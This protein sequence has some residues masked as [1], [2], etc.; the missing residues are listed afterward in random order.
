[1][2]GPPSPLSPSSPMSPMSPMSPG[3]GRKMSRS[4]RR[5]MRRLIK[6]R[7]TPPPTDKKELAAYRKRVAELRKGAGLPPRRTKG[8]RAARRRRAAAARAA[9]AAEGQQSPTPAPSQRLQARSFWDNFKGKPKG[10]L[11]TAQTQRISKMRTACEENKNKRKRGSC[12]DDVR[13]LQITMRERN[14]FINR[15]RSTT[16]KKDL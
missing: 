6:L 14:G 7:Q 15:V 9:A 5:S 11:T 10:D 1:M 2:S 12:N 16:G 13:R 4:Q 3:F 8:G